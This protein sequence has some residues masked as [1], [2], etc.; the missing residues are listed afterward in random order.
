[1]KYAILAAAMFAA[2]PALAQ[3]TAT[4]TYMENGQTPNNSGSG[5]GKIDPNA[6]ATPGRDNCR[7]VMERANSMA[8]PT[9]PA[10]ADDAD[11]QMALAEDARANGD[12]RL[13]KHHAEIALHDKT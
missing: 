4:P 1:M 11:R 7:Q 3:Q 2:M 9:D 13:C 8:R 5:A 10:R 12:F 6:D